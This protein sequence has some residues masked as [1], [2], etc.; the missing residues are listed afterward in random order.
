VISDAGRKAASAM[1]G[2]V[3]DSCEVR[4]TTRTMPLYK[5]GSR[6]SFAVDRIISCKTVAEL[7]HEAQNM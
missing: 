4:I 7:F 3:S 1:V 6:L 2:R 5:I